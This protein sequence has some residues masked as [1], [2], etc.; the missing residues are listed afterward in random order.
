MAND[1]TVPVT[2]D[3]HLR[4]YAHAHTHARTH[5]YTHMCACMHTHTHTHTHSECQRFANRPG[6][7]VTLEGQL[8]VRV[9]R[10]RTGE[11]AS[12]LRPGGEEGYRWFWFERGHACSRLGS[13]ETGGELEPHGRGCSGRLTRLSAW[14]ISDGGRRGASGHP[15]PRRT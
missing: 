15:G 13:E 4:K 10:H 14:R 7:D 1:V 6:Q 12:V 5:T 11:L 8:A 9:G 2:E 3:P